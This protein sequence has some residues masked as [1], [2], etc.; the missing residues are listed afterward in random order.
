LQQLA[1]S[2]VW[3]QAEQQCHGVTRQS[4]QRVV[5]TVSVG[6]LVVIF[7]VILL[8]SSALMLVL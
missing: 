4:Q 7:F 1:E 6:A 3:K 8:N 5:F 2:S